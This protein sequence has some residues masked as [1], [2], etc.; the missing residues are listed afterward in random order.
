MIY[1]QLLR[2]IKRAAIEYQIQIKDH[3]IL[4]F[5]WDNLNAVDFDG[6]C[7]RSGHPSRM[8]LKKVQKLGIKH[9]ISLRGGE[10][11]P[12]NIRERKHCAALGL[13][14]IN[15]PMSSAKVPRKETLLDLIEV[16]EQVEGPILLHCKT[17]ADRTGLAA[18]IYYLH[19]VENDPQKARHQL[20]VKYL[21]FGFGRKKLL[22]KFFEYYAETN[23]T[24][25][26]VKRWVTNKYSQQRFTDFLSADALKNRY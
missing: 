20:A 1:D 21:H 2:P 18:G 15:V 4:R 17:G 24:N 16:F 10:T 22:K 5:F 26:N 12:H 19:D 14:Y 25:M 8:L 23:T 6:R 7:L 13:E 9:I 11:L 3:A